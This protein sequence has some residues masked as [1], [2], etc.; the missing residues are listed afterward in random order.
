MLEHANRQFVLVLLVL[1]GALASS[2]FNQPAWGLDLRGGTQL[3]Y[4]VNIDRAREQHR[5]DPDA[6]PDQIM[7][8]TLVIINER[9]DPSGTRN[10]VITRQGERQ[11]LIE[12]PDVGEAEA[13]IIQGQIE[14]L[15]RLEMRIVADGD[16]DKDGVKFDL[17][18]EKKRLT[19]WLDKEAEPGVTNRQKLAANP[20]HILWFNNLPGDT[21]KVR[22]NDELMWY[23]GKLLP[24]YQDPS[25]WDRPASSYMPDVVA[26]FDPAEYQAGPPADWTGS[27][28]PYLV[29]L[30]PI[31]MKEIGFT[32][33]Q[34]DASGVRKGH[35]PESGRPCVFYK[36]KAGKEADDY[37]DWSEEYKGKPSAIILNN[38]V[39]SAPVFSG[40]IYG[41][42]IITGQFSEQEASD[43][44]KV[45]K[46]GSLQVKPELVQRT[47]IGATLGQ[48]SIDRGALSIG[49]GGLFVLV[50]IL[51]YYRLAGLVAFIAIAMNVFLIWAV[52]LFVRA[53]ITLPGIA[54]LVLTMGMAVDANILIYERIRE[55]LGKGKDLLQGV[56]VGFE[57][58]MVTILDANI[59]TFI[60][61]LVLYNVGVGPV[62]GFAVTLMVGICTSLFTAFFVSRLVF[63]YLLL[64]K[65]MTRFNVAEFLTKFRF[66][67]VAWGKAAFSISVIV[68]IAGLAYVA[69][70]PA[71]KVLALDFTGGAALEVQLKEPMSRADMV[72]RLASDPEFAKDFPDPLVNTLDVRD[73]KSTRFSIKLKLTGAQR[74]H[75]AELREQAEQA[76]KTFEPPYKSELE[77]VMG[78]S[79]VDDAF[80]TVKIGEIG[81]GVRIADVDARFAAPVSVAELNQRFQKRFGDGAGVAVAPGGNETADTDVTINF[82][83][84]PNQNES[85]VTN[86]VLET[87]AGLVDVEG[88][89]ARLSDPI[90][91]AAEIGGRMVGELRVSAL[92]AIILSLFFIVMYIRVR[93]HEYKYG[94]AAVVALV[95]DVMVT[96]VVVVTANQLGLVNAEI[97]LNM[98]AAFLTIIGY[99]IN[100][101]IVI[102]DRVRENVSD[103]ERLGDSHESF[104][105]ILNRSINQTL[106]RTVLT[107]STTLFVVLATFVVN[108]GSASGLEG[109]SFALLVGIVSGTYST[110][111]IA[112]PV[113]LWLRNREQ[114]RQ[115]DGGA[116]VKTDSSNVA[117]ES[118]V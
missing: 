99:S 92:G 102:F 53:T 76:D 28:P 24:A 65:R 38:I 87:L 45:I 23:V 110:I 77:R 26:A 12:L 11:F 84:A 15:G 8:E 108:R 47:T 113:V 100:D 39:R 3:I 57:R 86:V 94:L 109:F 112:S 70:V 16:F 81:D 18:E 40:R 9:I 62:R 90:P 68:I 91:N 33:E 48:E 67:F 35:D 74:E 31:N 63:H 20:E 85:D 115:S 21:G 106:S 88:N 69:T 78:A 32:G 101:T 118:T 5:V 83:V 93:F 105:A 64:S 43:L 72:A 41:T 7:R 37:A 6:D 13:Q 71:D 36:L 42:G 73:G 116:A 27:E 19:A 80:S 49:V 52:V 46:T 14:N 56:R 103:Q 98:I 60:A 54:G 66:D 58:A 97:D 34:M 59:T 75:Y 95:H 10:A 44:A 79:L 82:V 114:R 50:F 104:G 55:E 25:T 111:F 17:P 29:E 2:L 89:P 51:A 30:Y 117:L 96:L 107:S 61:G 22:S 4:R 1:A